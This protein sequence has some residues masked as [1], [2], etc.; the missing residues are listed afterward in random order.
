MF[1]KEQYTQFLPFPDLGF[2]KLVD[3]RHKIQ[4]RSWAAQA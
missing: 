4:L 3:A 1:G 2:M